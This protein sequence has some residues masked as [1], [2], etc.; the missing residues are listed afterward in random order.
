MRKELTAE[1]SERV[2]TWI[3]VVLSIEAA[4]GELVVIS[5]TTLVGT[6]QQE[7]QLAGL[8]HIHLNGSE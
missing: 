1:T 3:P 6:A 8:E 2:A 4:I 5:P 7:E